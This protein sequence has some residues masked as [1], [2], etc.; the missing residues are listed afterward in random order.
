MDFEVEKSDPVYKLLRQVKRLSKGKTISQKYLNKFKEIPKIMK[1]CGAVK[2][3]IIIGCLSY[4]LFNKKELKES[5]FKYKLVSKKNDLIYFNST[6]ANLEQFRMNNQHYKTERR[7]SK[8][9]YTEI[10]SFPHGNLKIIDYLDINEMAKELDFK[11]FP[12]PNFYYIWTYEQQK[13]KVKTKNEIG[14]NEDISISLESI[15][16]EANWSKKKLPIKQTIAEIEATEQDTYFDPRLY[17]MSIFDKIEYLKNTGKINYEEYTIKSA[18]ALNS[19]RFK[20]YKQMRDNMTTKTGA[21]SRA[22][23]HYR[24][25]QYSISKSKKGYDFSQKNMTNLFTNTSESPK[26]TNRNLDKQITLPFKAISPEKDVSTPSTKMIRRRSRSFKG[27]L[28]ESLNYSKVNIRKSRVKSSIRRKGVNSYKGSPKK[29]DSKLSL[30]GEGKKISR[31]Y[32]KSRVS[33]SAKDKR[34]KIE[35]RQSDSTFK[36]GKMKINNKI[37]NSGG[38]K[39]RPRK[40]TS[41]NPSFFL[42]KKKVKKN[43]EKKEVK[44]FFIGGKQK[45][46]NKNIEGISLLL[47]KEANKLRKKGLMLPNL[48]NT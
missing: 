31:F 25:K 15:S 1:T 18:V 46:V 16:D 11:D 44:S 2:R 13:I 17:K 32:R 4:I 42:R 5:L 22:M 20:P 19:K 27:K 41:A 28:V 23:S 30:D 3:K 40:K 34:Y 14:E 39:R 10:S 37:N 33:L 36:R 7:S 24:R 6:E 8:L 9:Y 29:K 47:K 12:D 26:K 35:T 45:A 43:S 21:R 38:I 48:G